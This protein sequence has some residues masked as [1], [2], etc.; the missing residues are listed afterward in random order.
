[1]VDHLDLFAHD[2]TSSGLDHK[3]YE[4]GWSTWAD[5]G[6]GMSGPPAAVSWAVGR[7]DVFAN[8]QTAQSGV[9]GDLVHTWTNA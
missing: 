8:G 4:Q 1:M 5:E 3:S 6:G 2:L 7:T 9:T